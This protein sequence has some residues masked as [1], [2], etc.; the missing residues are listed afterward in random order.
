M[1][2]KDEI[3]LHDY[4]DDLLSP[5]EKV[6]F[7]EILVEYIDL[8][9]DLRKLKTLKRILQNLPMAFEPSEILMENISKTILE[10]EEMYIHPEPESEP[11]PKKEKKEKKKKK[12]KKDLLEES[13]DEESPIEESPIEE[14]PIEDSLIEDSSVLESF[15]E[16]NFHEESPIIEEPK[17]E[18]PKKEKPKKE[19]SDKKRPPKKRPVSRKR[20]GL[21]GKTK[22]RIKQFI[23]FL[24]SVGFVGAVL[25]GYYFYL[26]IDS[27]FPWKVNVIS[28][29]SQ[30]NKNLLPNFIDNNEHLVT[31]KDNVIRITVANKGF[32]ELNGECEIASI[33]GTQSLN[34]VLLEKGNL[35]FSPLQENNL[36]LLLYGDIKIRSVNS[37]FELNAPGNASATLNVFSNFVEIEVG[38]FINKVPYNHTIKVL[39][40]NHI[41]IPV[42]TSSSKRFTRLVNQFGMQQSDKTLN[43]ILN[44][45]KK[46]NAFTLLF[47]L[48]KV[49]PGN[50]D[51]I[52]NKLQKFF[53][54]PDSITKVDI[55]LLDDEALNTWWL[56]IYGS[57]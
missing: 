44:L 20:K 17:R 1:K 5:G 2:N 31:Y 26:Q 51:L 38:D 25:S 43:S 30:P 8:A 57:L 46:E 14:S 52:I 19:K 41:S 34:S 18:K 10:A 37:E 16:E 32:I 4:F 48:N 28:E 7:E 42:I 50:K 55:L 27:T 29:S 11:K 15:I 6:E 13:L 56:E 22:F 36:F 47:M 24:L 53:P 54:L 45:S 23:Y 33:N 40:E 3:A 9:I 39:D 49:T 21:R 12:K 35:K